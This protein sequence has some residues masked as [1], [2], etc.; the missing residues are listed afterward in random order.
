MYVLF[1]GGSA[2]SSRILD[3]AT[4]ARLEVRSVLAAVGNNAVSLI[5]AMDPTAAE[6]S[7]R[8][9]LAEG[10]TVSA[11]LLPA[12]IRKSRTQSTIAPL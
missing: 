1:A 3:C 2:G 11:V 4:L 8:Q 6:A 7:L 10:K 5:D 9:L 12:V